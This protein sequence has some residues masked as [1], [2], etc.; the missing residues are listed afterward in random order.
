MSVFEQARLNCTPFFWAL[1]TA[2]E[3]I[4]GDYGTNLS[5]GVPRRERPTPDLRSQ[6]EGQNIAGA[7]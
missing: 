3:S 6:I 4:A 5:W 1:S 2:R 7:T